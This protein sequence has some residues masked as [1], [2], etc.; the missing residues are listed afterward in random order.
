MN[1]D[2]FFSTMA[3]MAPQNTENLHIFHH[4]KMFHFHDLFALAQDG[5]TMLDMITTNTYLIN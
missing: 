1:Y 4:W 5:M 2:F 3:V